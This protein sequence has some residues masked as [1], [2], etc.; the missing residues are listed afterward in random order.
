[1][2]LE[3]YS[4]NETVSIAMKNK[5]LTGQ[6]KECGTHNVCRKVFSEIRVL[7]CFTHIEPD[8]VM[9]SSSQEGFI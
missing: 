1:M 3:K 9:Y 7:I 8:P 2:V 5:L 6:E 4:G